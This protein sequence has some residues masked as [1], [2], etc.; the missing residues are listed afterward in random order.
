MFGLGMPELLVVTVLALLVFGPKS[1]P[2]LGSGLA[3]AIRGFKEGAEPTSSAPRLRS[4]ASSSVC[5]HC[6]GANAGDAAFCG[7]CGKK[8]R[9][10]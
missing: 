10:S 5:P 4:S 1:L 7:Q 9:E 8:Q 3:K 6:G 2:D